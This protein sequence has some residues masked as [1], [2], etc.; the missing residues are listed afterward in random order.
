MSKT[1]KN[2]VVET[3]DNSIDTSATIVDNEPKAYLVK[4]EDGYHIE[5]LEGNI[6]D[7]CKLVDKDQ[8][9]VFPANASNR[10]CIKVTVAEKFFAENGDDAKMAL[11]YKATRTIGQGVSRSTRLPN[12]K[13]I[14]YL[15]EAEQEE[16]K[17]II[18]R[19]IAAR[20]AEREAN[21]KKP[22]TETEKAQAKVTKLLAQLKEMG[23][24]DDEIKAIIG[25][26][27]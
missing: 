5:D 10:K 11:L 6:S 15:P 21:K 4:K 9:I 18:A 8:W 13:L 20:D 7:V 14:S 24:S 22:M 1:T 27:N 12:E 23:V 26:T 19:A 2:D 17:A 25:G 3:V 16:Y